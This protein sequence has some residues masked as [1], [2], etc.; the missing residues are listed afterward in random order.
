MIEVNI[1]EPVCFC[2]EVRMIPIPSSL[3]QLI[4]SSSQLSRMAELSLIG[5]SQNCAFG[6]GIFFF[7]FHS[8]ILVGLH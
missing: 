6:F 5:W 4:K 8:G 7:L 3:F 1:I 2:L